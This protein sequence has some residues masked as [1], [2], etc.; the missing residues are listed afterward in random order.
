MSREVLRHEYPAENVPLAFDDTAILARLSAVDENLARMREEQQQAIS[1]GQSG[2]DL[3]L[4]AFAALGYALSARALLL[5]ALIGAFSLAV[6]AEN[7][8]TAMSL[9][10][11]IAYAAFVIVPIV[12]LEIRKG[13]A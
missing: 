9:G 6:M 3:A 7:N 5:L 13:K 8:G 1:G 2:I 4:T 10:I 11:L 12:V